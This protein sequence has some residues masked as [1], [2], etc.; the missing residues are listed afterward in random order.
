MDSVV[1]REKQRDDKYIICPLYIA[2]TDHEIRCQAHV[3]DATAT[4]LRY[5]DMGRCQ[6]QRKTYCEGCWKRCEHYL[7]WIH[8][9]WEEEE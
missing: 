9:R 1:M 3:P 2:H 8:F 5:S 4:I 7:T 6:A